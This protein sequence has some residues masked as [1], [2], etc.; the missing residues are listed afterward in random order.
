MSIDFCEN[1]FAQ[2]ARLASTV[3]ETEGKIT[4]WVHHSEAKDPINKY[5]QQI[6]LKRKVYIRES[7]TDQVLRGFTFLEET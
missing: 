3:R 1:E 5:L 7:C 4:I 2:F 6:L